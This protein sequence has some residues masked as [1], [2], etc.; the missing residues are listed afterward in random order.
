MDA[1]GF[2]TAA[3]RRALRGTGIGGRAVVTGRSAVGDASIGELDVVRPAVEYDRSGRQVTQCPAHVTAGVM[4][5]GDYQEHRGDE[6]AEGEP[7]QV[8]TPRLA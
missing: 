5:P 1:D 3:H 4:E 7:D 2:S 6:H 8:G